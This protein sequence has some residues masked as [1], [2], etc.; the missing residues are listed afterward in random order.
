M[1]VM[2]SCD[3]T[4]LQ[5]DNNCM[6]WT[7]SVVHINLPNPSRWISNPAASIPD[8][9]QEASPRHL[10]VHP[11]AGC[12]CVLHLLVEY[13]G[14]WS[15]LYTGNVRV[16]VWHWL[17]SVPV[18][19]MLPWQL[20]DIWIALMLYHRLELDVCKVITYTTFECDANWFPPLVFWLGY[21]T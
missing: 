8:P 6:C 5:W 2:W 10:P 3:G 18:C 1:I 19:I 17:W 14:Q 16:A 4:A 12:L 7:Q 15:G 9:L 11:G 20:D 21:Y 13:R